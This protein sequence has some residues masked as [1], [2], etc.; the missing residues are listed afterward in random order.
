MADKNVDISKD[1]VTKTARAIK[2]SLID[3]FVYCKRCGAE[4]D[5]DSNFCKRCGK[6]Q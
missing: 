6:Q 2:S 1:A 4:I 5:D 3:E